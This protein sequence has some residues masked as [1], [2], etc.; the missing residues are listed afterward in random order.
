M[1]SIREQYIT[2]AQLTK[3]SSASG[4]SVRDT[5][6]LLWFVGASLDHQEG[7]KPS[8]ALLPAV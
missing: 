2:P 8:P 7:L 4:P 1:K 5:F 3:V 6:Q